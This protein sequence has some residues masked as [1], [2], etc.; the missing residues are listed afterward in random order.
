MSED[1]A[2]KLD[3][4]ID[5][6]EPEQETPEPEQTEEQ[7]QEPEQEPAEESAEEEF[8]QAEFLE[9]MMDKAEGAEP[10]A[11][12]EAPNADPVEAKE[13]PAKDEA[14]GE[15][16][17]D[18]EILNAIPSERGKERIRTLLRQGRESRAQ[19][20]AFQRTVQESGL[21]Q[22][23]FANLLTITKL[24]SSSN[25]QDVERGLA[26]LEAVRTQLYTMLGREAPGVDLL[27]GHADLQSRVDDLSMTREDAL[28]LAKARQLQ[29]EQDRQRLAAEKQQQEMEAYKSRVDAFQSKATAMFA[30]K[31][32]ELDFNAKVQIM[33]E[34]FKKPGALERFVR[35]VPPEQWLSTLEYMYDTIQ[36]PKAAPA[37]SPI[38]G[39]NHMRTGYRSRGIEEFDPE[40]SVAN[41]MD[42]M[43][44]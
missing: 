4:L 32:N 20:E 41:I 17:E 11:K 14:K 30:G 3:D 25:A 16:D 2:K 44:L 23:S 18:A 33:S 21:D 15:E 36:A 8:D 26:G 10:E 34:H 35:D 39:V 5:E 13:T 12:E 31:Q 6:Q 24:C 19:V 1:V 22:E 27:K 37:P 40:K 28:T 29:A 42:S 9:K 7:E 43:G 38:A